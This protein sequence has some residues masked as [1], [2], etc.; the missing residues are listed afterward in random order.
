MLPN[1]LLPSSEYLHKRI[2]QHAT[3][4]CVWSY[5]DLIS[6]TLYYTIHL[7]H[8]S[9]CCKWCGLMAGNIGLTQESCWV[10]IGGIAG[11]PITYSA[12]TTPISVHSLHCS[13]ITIVSCRMRLLRSLRSADQNLLTIKRYNFE[14]YGRQYLA[15]AG[16]ML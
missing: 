14:R 3:A 9:K 6:V 5:R 11:L 1:G 10:R 12:E 4:V 16:H 13:R 8:S 7:N 2:R 15:V